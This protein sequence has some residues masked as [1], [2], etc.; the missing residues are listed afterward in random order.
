[1]SSSTLGAPLGGTT[2][3]GQAGFDRVAL[4][5]ISPSNF[6]GGAGTYRPSIVAVAAGEPG[7]PLTCWACAV[8]AMIG[9]ANHA[10]SRVLSFIARLLSGCWA[11]RA[12]RCQCL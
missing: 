1:M 9:I 10:A 6:C 5:L 7:V 4:R 8:M 3:A 12:V 11:A 2:G